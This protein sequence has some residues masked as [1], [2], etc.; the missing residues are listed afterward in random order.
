V[1]GRYWE[2]RS[3]ASEGRRQLAAL[4]TLPGAEA[5]HTSA[6]NVL[7]C[8]GMLALLQ[9]DVASA[10]PVLK[11]SLAL[12]RQRGDPSGLA[13]ALIHFGFLCL[14]INLVGAVEPPS[15]FSSKR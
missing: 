5:R 1:L 7:D 11:E 10:R 15:A 4:L 3:L 12:Y 2:V 9:G 6:G 8:A 14:G 13:W